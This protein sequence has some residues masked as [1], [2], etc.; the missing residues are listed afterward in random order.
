MIGSKMKCPRCNGRL[1]AE[2]LGG[3]P[4]PVGGPYRSVEQPDLEQVADLI[5]IDR[6]NH[7]LGLWFDEGEMNRAIQGLKL[8]SMPELPPPR[9]APSTREQIGS[10]PRC[11]SEMETLESQAVDGIV[12]DRCT[13]CNGVWFDPGEAEAFSDRHVGLL[14]LML[15]EFG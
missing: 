2:T 15:H 4:V 11:R 6:C 12:Y 3:R 14:A 7:C 8:R 9:E 13:S 5:V 1:V 10:C